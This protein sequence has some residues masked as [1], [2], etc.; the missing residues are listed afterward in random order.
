[1]TSSA[2]RF[3]SGIHISSMDAILR[4]YI[5]VLHS[6]SLSFLCVFS[7]SYSPSFGKRNT[8]CWQLSITFC[9]FILLFLLSPAVCF[10]VRHCL[11]HE[12]GEI[13]SRLAVGH[14]AAGLPSDKQQGN[15]DCQS[16]RQKNNQQI[17]RGCHHVR[18]DWTR[19]PIKLSCF[20]LSQSSPFT[21][22]NRNAAPH[23][24]N[25]PGPYISYQ[26]PFPLADVDWLARKRLSTK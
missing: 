19:Y 20:W 6:S 14:G 8:T 10:E 13:I 3:L 25:T 22:M 18:N 2:V 16:E 4:S 12:R 23:K 15:Q 26:S 5:F 7:V 24:K 17:I 21:G 11:R 1:M 9:S